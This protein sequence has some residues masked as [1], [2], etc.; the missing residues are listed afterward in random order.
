MNNSITSNQVKC[1]NCAIYFLGGKRG[2]IMIYKELK[3]INRKNE[4]G[5]VFH[6]NQNLIEKTG[7]AI[8]THQVSKQKRYRLVKT[9]MQQ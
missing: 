3:A 2:I 5:I 9:N 4:R 8:N 7:K 6:G 1:Q